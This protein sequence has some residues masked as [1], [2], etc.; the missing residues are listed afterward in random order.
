M[1]SA[2]TSV[3]VCSECDRLFAG[4]HDLDWHVYNDHLF[5]HTDRLLRSL[6]K[7]RHAPPERV[8]ELS[9]AQRRAIEA[10]SAGHGDAG[11]AST[12]AA[13]PRHPRHP[14]PTAAQRIAIRL[15]RD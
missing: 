3:L 15:M 5:G 14:R 11:D 7:E 9:D 6:R 2:T 1:R 4:T 10:G 13:A 8:K 12:F